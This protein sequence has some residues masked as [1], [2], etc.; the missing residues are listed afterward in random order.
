MDSWKY[1]KLF[2]MVVCPLVQLSSHFG[3]DS[4][5]VEEGLSEEVSNNGLSALLNY[6]WLC[7][8]IPESYGHGTSEEKLYSKYTDALISQAYNFMGLKSLVLTERADAADGR[9]LRRIT[10]LLQM[11]RFSVLAALP[12]TRRISRFRRWIAGNMASSSQ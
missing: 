10:V 5:Q 3:S 4:T 7:S 8:A 12:R 1:G 9:A 6:L 2:A 11:A